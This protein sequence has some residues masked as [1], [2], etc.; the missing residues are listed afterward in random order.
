MGTGVRCRSDDLAPIRKM[1]YAYTQ[2]TLRLYPKRKASPKAGARLVHQSSTIFRNL[3]PKIILI[4]SEL[5]SRVAR[6]APFFI[7]TITVTGTLIHHTRLIYHL[8]DLFV[9]IEKK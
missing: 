9:G 8:N 6:V 1:L 3:A 7:D 4:L 5:Q 2:N